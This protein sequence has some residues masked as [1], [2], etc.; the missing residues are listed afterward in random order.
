MEY[1]IDNFIVVSCALGFLTSCIVWLKLVFYRNLVKKIDQSMSVYRDI[2][3]G[4]S[5]EFSWSTEILSR[6]DGILTGED[7]QDRPGPH[8][9]ALR[10][11]VSDKLRKRGSG[12]EEKT[13]CL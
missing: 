2:V 10:R 5:T 1:V 3:A 12:V 6:I 8:R 9:E 7:S 11:A 13:I 4:G